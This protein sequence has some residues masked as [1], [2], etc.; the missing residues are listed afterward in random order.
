[1]LRHEDLRQKQERELSGTSDKA[2][3]STRNMALRANSG[4]SKGR[5]KST[6]NTNEKKA[7][8]P[9]KK[10]LRCG[11]CDIKDSHQEEDC[12][13]KFPEKKLRKPKTDN[14]VESR[15]YSSIQTQARTQASWIID[16]SATR[17][18]TSNFND[19]YNYKAYQILIR[20][21]G[22]SGQLDTLGEEKTNLF[23]V[24]TNN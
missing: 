5:T 11:F 24:S 12:W 15:H 13:K 16:P 14:D 22:I 4:A 19:L 10:G 2:V 18:L 17:H 1:M 6:Q 8:N 23:C 7:R 3:D 21:D 20:A 9:D